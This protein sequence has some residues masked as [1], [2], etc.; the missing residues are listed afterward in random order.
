MYAR[1]FADCK[2]KRKQVKKHFHTGCNYCFSVI[3]GNLT[4][5]LKVTFLPFFI[6]IKGILISYEAIIH[7]NSN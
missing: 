6:Y 4:E 1:S 5:F 7:E 2:K 3:Q